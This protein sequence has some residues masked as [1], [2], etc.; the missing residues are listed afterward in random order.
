VLL[1]RHGDHRP[2]PRRT[3]RSAAARRRDRRQ[4]WHQ[5][6]QPPATGDGGVVPGEPH[7]HRPREAVRRER[8]HGPRVRRHGHQARGHGGQRRHPAAG[9]HGG[10]GRVGGGQRGALLP[11]DGHL[12]RG[13]GERDRGHGRP[14]PDRQPGAR[15]ARAPVRTRRGGVPPDPRVDAALPRHARVPARPTVHVPVPRRARPRRVRA[16]AG[17]PPEDTVAVRGEPVPVLRVQRRDA[18]LRAG[19]AQPRGGRPRDGDRVH[20][21]A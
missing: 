6:R 19:A 21:H 4:L 2:R 17:V 10:R 9:H 13:R 12:A 7:A 16:D 11:G 5:G 14:G 20:Q 3:L 15:H 18:G 1:P 8:R